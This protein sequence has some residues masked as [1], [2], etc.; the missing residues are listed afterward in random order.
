MRNGRAHLVPRSNISQP[1][2]APFARGMSSVTS[3]VFVARWSH[4]RPTGRGRGI[5]A[6]TLSGW[7]LME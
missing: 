7:R 4:E 1:E 2:I 6:E 5:T 3:T